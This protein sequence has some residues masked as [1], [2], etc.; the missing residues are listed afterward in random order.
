MRLIFLK[1]YNGSFG[2]KTFIGIHIREQK[3][4]QKYCDENDQILMLNTC[5]INDGYHFAIN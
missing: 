5:K 2:H 4:K 3:P 1:N